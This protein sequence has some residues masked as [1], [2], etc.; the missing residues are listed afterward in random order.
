[1]MERI[2]GKRTENEAWWGV[3]HPVE[4]DLVGLS[5]LYY[6]KKFWKNGHF[7]FRTAGCDGNKNINLVLWGDSY[8]YNIP[9]SAFSCLSSYQFGRRYFQKLNYY[10]D[11]SK[12]NILLIEISERFV[13]EYFRGTGIYDFVAKTYNTKD[14]VSVDL[15]QS[16][17][18]VKGTLDKFFNPNINQNIEYNLFNY[19]FISDIRKTKA[20]VNY[21]FFSRASGDVV[22][23]DN[24]SYLF[25][26]EAVDLNN[27]KSSYAPVAP[28]SF[29]R[30]IKTL[31]D[32]YEH[33]REEGFAEVYL[34]VIPNPS[35]IIQPSGYNK[36]IPM[37][38]TDTSLKIKLIDIYTPFVNTRKDVYWHGDTHWNNTGLN[39]WID[40]VNKMLKKESIQSVSEISPS[41]KLEVL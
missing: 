29:R 28:P 15:P 21:H 4:G 7:S 26:K 22:I 13:L 39:M 18:A 30:V 38:Q 6:E 23:A 34:S 12:R 3:R 5:Y 25:L 14:A 40:E 24:D 35:S 33:Y 10:I 1:M 2:S 31:N 20:W 11:T 19:N 36:L 16:G 41:R 8:T 37:L 17:H 9:D 32:I 27:P